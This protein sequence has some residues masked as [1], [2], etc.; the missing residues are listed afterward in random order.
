MRVPLNCHRNRC[1]VLI[2]TANFMHIRNESFNTTLC[3]HTRK[4]ERV[5]EQEKKKKNKRE[6]ERQRAIERESDWVCEQFREI[7]RVRNSINFVTA[8]VI[9][10]TAAVAAFVRLW[11]KHKKTFYNPSF[12]VVYN[13]FYCLHIESCACFFLLHLFLI[14]SLIRVQISVFFFC[15][16]GDRNEKTK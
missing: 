1:V 9:A 3:S 11:K 12:G 5:S 15:T 16:F 14:L 7:R 13:R 8:F 4:N 6:R 10:I 2:V